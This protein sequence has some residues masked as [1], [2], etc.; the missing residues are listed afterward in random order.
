MRISVSGRVFEVLGYECGQRSKM[1]QRMQHGWR[2]WNRWLI[3]KVELGKRRV[4]ESW[5]RLECEG[6]RRRGCWLV[7]LSERKDLVSE[8]WQERGG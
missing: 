7:L 2:R 4:G 3:R 8:L 5:G 6:G 1:K